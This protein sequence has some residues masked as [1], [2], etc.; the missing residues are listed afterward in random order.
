MPQV[1][2]TNIKSRKRTYYFGN[3]FWLL[4]ISRS[5]QLYFERID[6]EITKPL[7]PLH[8]EWL[9]FTLKRIFNSSAYLKGQF[10]TVPWITVPLGFLELS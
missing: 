6:S 2:P 7:C 9:L 4:K 5:M 1:G 3:P 10:V 8:L